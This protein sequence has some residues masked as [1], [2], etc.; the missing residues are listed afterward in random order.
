MKLAFIHINFK[1]CILTSAETKE[2]IAQDL[3]RLSEEIVLIDTTYTISYC[4]V[5][6]Y[7]HLYTILAFSD[8]TIKSYIFLIHVKQQNFD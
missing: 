6:M 3:V 7:T 1:I 8:T 2:L 4:I 5:N